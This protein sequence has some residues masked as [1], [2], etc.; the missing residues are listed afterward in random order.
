MGRVVQQQTTFM[1]RSANERDIPLL[2]V[3][4]APVDEL[5]RPA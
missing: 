5:G 4:N 2:E 3:A 1:E